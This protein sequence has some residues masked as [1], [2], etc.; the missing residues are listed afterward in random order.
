MAHGTCEAIAVAMTTRQHGHEQSMAC[1]DQPW[2]I[3]ADMPWMNHGPVLM[4]IQWRVH[5][6]PRLV[7]DML[8]TFPMP[9]YVGHAVSM[10][11][12]IP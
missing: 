9:C 4:D 5:G 10:L 6:M 1:H 7:H 11:W 8:V 12:Y 2:H 3:P